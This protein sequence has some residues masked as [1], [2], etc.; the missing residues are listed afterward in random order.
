MEN[1]FVGHSFTSEHDF[2][3]SADDYSKFKFGDGKVASRFGRQLALKF[4]KSRH[5]AACKGHPIAIVPSPHSYLPT[6]SYF[7]AKSF[8]NVI[9]TVLAR[10]GHES[11]QWVKIWRTTSYLNDY[12]NLS[13]QE[14]QNLIG[15]DRYST[16]L[17]LLK[18][19]K[20]ISIDDVRITGT[21]QL[22]L[23]NMFQKYGLLQNVTFV[24]FAGLSSSQTNPT[25]ENVLNYHYVK[26]I[27]QVLDII[28]GGGFKINTRVIKFILSQPVNELEAFLSELPVGLAKQL[29]LS[30]IG[31]NYHLEP[32][33]KHSIAYFNAILT[34]NLIR[35]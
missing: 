10:K 19:C 22:V 32:S 30:A 4:L 24:Y 34:P 20:I 15:N 6:A 2:S 7:L 16:N 25:I 27:S 35:L 29:Y 21:H 8:A 12:G 17:D 3:F 33:F 5:W 23:E 28:K 18:D 31:N 14:R 26:H 9:N 11:S 1:S 13:A